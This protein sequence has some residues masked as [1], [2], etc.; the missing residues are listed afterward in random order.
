MFAALVILILTPIVLSGFWPNGMLGIS[1]WDYYFS[2]HHVVREMTLEYGI[3]P[4]W[5]PYIC[6]GTSAIGDPEFPL[7]APTF[8][9]ELAFGIPLGFRLAIFAVIAGGGI[10]MLLLG[11]RLGL[12]VWAALLAG[13]AFAFGSV[14]LLEIVEGHPNV[15]SAAYVPWVLWVW[16]NSYAQ[17]RPSSPGGLGGLLAWSRARKS[18]S[19]RPSPSEPAAGA[20]ENEPG[21]AWALLGGI[22]LALMFFQGGIY[23]LMYLTG[24]FVFLIAMARDKKRALLV[25]IVAGC[26]ALGL[27]AIKLVPVLLWLKEFQDQA[28]ASS[29]LTLPYLHDIFLGRHL[30]GFVSESVIPGQEGGWHEYG[31]YLGPFALALALI[32]A[33]KFKQSRLVRLLLLG[34]VIAV[35]VSSAGPLLQPL[36]DQAP[37]LPRSSISRLVLFAVIP[38]C[39]LAGI[40]LD[41]GKQLLERQVRHRW[42]LTTYYVLLTAFVAIDLGTFA[43]QLS[44]QAFVVPP[45]DEPVAAAPLPL[46]Y[47]NDAWTYRLPHASPAPAGAGTDYTRGYTGIQHGYGTITYCSVLS[48]DRAVTL[49]QEADGEKFVGLADDVG[50]AQVVSWQPQ[51]VVVDVTATEPT[52]AVLNANKARGWLAN[53]QPVTDYYN[54]VAARV[55]AGRQTVVFAY[56]AP[57]YRLGQ[58]ITIVTTLLL[59]TF[60]LRRRNASH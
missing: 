58:A 25:T 31:A 29:A 19:S 56:R 42:L 21:D 20:G 2:Y 34:G 5:N 59:L 8:L 15:F 33:S 26:I 57:G 28:Y 22:L 1:D 4:Q 53:G 49:L 14:N 10:G 7:F 39:L 52:L 44:H 47:T 40:G 60:I 17:Q 37:F 3:I 24:A 51:E 13:I 27:A 6:G 16:L 55:P 12:S 50:T 38:L 35:L 41:Q 18:E 11:K 45:H 23:M 48:P 54:K 36:F 32:G 30:H 43:N 46:A 9:L